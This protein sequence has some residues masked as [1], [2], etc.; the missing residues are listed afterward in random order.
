MKLSYIL[1]LAGL[2]LTTGASA[3]SL[4]FEYNLG[5]GTYYMGGPTDYVRD[6]KPSYPLSAIENLKVTD[7][8]PGYVTHGGK[9][10]IGWCK[11]HEA[12]ISFDYMNT[13]GNKG[14]ADYSGSYT[15]TF[16]V[17]GYRLGDYYRFIIP[18][19][20]EKRVRPYL[21]FTT[22]AVFNRGEVKQH[23][24]IND[25]LDESGEEVLDGVNFFVEPAVGMKVYLYARFALNLS[26]GYQFDLNYNFRYEGRKVA[27]G[28][29]WT[30]WRLQAG[31]VYTIPLSR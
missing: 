7:K 3:Q 15:M 1:L 19:T 31:L 24:V 18:G 16:R 25:E 6:F 21:Q 4:S 23:L 9:V 13:V 12:G 22:G 26:V 17:K 29:D 2:L 11:Y 10:G 20:L 28:P 8:F 5:Y 27:F 14:V 30:G